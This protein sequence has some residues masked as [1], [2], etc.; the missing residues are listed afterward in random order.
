MK[1]NKLPGTDINISVMCLGSG[2]WGGGVQNTEQQG[3]D[4]MDYAFSKGVNFFDTAELYPIPP[5]PSTQGATERVIGTW[6][7]KR[8][9]RSKIVLATKI[10][11]PADYT[12]HL[13]K[14]LGYHKKALDHAIEQS[15]IRLQ[16][17]Y[18]DLFQIHWPERKTNFFGPRGYVHDETCTWKSNFYEILEHLKN[19]IK[20]GNIRYIGVCNETPWGVMKFLEMGKNNKLPLVRT[21]QNPYSLLNRL[22]EVGNAEI[23][24]REEIGLL[25]YSPLGFGNLT[26][27]YLNKNK[28]KGARITM[29]PDY[30]RYS[31]NMSIKS[32][33]K[34]VTLAKNHGLRPAQMALSFVLSRPFLSSVIV[35]ATTMEQLK[36][37]IG[38]VELDLSVDIIDSINEIHDEQPNPAP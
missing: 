10:A 19:H 38:S 8:K 9:K 13:R 1:Y 28:P 25:A 27:K 36:E 15:L 30:D 33:E 24:H 7:K 5:V 18:I 26:G 20:I 22:F 3:H 23:C 35:G 32:I 37:N 6:F 11:G 21:I 14:Y 31:K 16:T 12:T 2:T 29:F 34:Y 17:D 4:Q